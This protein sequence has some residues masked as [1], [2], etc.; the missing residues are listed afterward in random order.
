MSWRHSGFNVF[1]GPR[2]FPHEE[3]AIENL[4][5]YIIRASFSQERM[6]YVEEH[7][8]VVYRSKDGA[9]QKVFD[10]LEWPRY[11]EAGCKHSRPCVLTSPIRESRWS[12]TMATTVMFPEANGR[13]R[14]K[15]ASYRASS[16]LMD[17]RKGVGRT[18]PGSPASG[19]L[20]RKIYEVDPL[21]CPKCKGRMRIA[22]FV[23]KRFCCT[24]AQSQCVLMM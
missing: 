9:E 11:K 1:S 8:I 4:A 24:A 10:A 12:A 6:S 15:T 19:G 7:G 14:T 3:T 22:G 21:V 2:I 17:Q 16:R 20:I 13:R 5:R 18:G 23:R